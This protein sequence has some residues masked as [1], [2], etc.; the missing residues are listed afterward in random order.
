MEP[1]AGFMLGLAGGFH[2][3]GM[4][5]P[6][7]TVV[8]KGM[9]YHLGRIAMYSITGGILGLTAASLSLLQIGSTV[10]VVAGVAMIVT[11]SLQIFWHWNVISLSGFAKY[12]QPLRN[13]VIKRVP[14]HK[15]IGRFILGMMNGILPCGLVAS[16]WLG[17]VSTGSVQQGMAFM[18]LF[19]LGT[20][21]A[22][23]AI[24]FGG[25]WFVNKVG[26]RYRMILPV[27]ALLVGCVVLLRGMELGIPLLSP[28]PVIVQ[29]AGCH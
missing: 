3:I 21:P 15:A 29:E 27:L 11:A 1:L 28:K 17:S 5:G 13:V 19:G 4:C 20:L 26:N 6:I 25:T 2:C 7:I 8:G 14:K 16:A 23:L 10:S 12:T 24:S 22:T 18:G 9:V